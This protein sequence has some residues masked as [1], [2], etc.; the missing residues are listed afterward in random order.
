M[1]TDGILSAVQGMTDRFDT[2]E[3]KNAGN[4]IFEMLADFDEDMWE[5]LTNSYAVDAW[6]SQHIKKAFISNPLREKFTYGKEGLIAKGD[7]L[8]AMNT[9]GVKLAENAYGCYGICC[10][11]VSHAFCLE[12]DSETLEE[13]K[14]K[15]SEDE[16]ADIVHDCIKTP[17]AAKAHGLDREEWKFIYSMIAVTFPSGEK[18]IPADV[19]VEN[20]SPKQ[21][22]DMYQILQK[23]E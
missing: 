6:L 9:G 20:M 23:M 16:I 21:K 12:T 1:V 4:A 3:A 7:I 13:F 5:K 17:E 10:V 11:I 19:L 18:D 14:E 22:K 8:R 15:Y 2:T